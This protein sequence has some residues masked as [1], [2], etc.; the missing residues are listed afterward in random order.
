MET[1]KAIFVIAQNQFR[2]E[3]LF[4]TQK[5]LKDAGIKTQIAC[6]TTQEA[7]GKL[8]GKASPDMSVYDINPEEIDALIFVGGG[9]CMEYY[10]DVRVLGIAKQ[11]FYAGKIVAA[12]CAAPSILVNAGILQGRH[13]TSHESRMQHLKDMGTIFENKPVVEDGKIITASGPK[14]AKEFGEALVRHLGREANNSKE[15]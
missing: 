7:A 8:G 5:I 11:V 6:K 9:G 3:E 10:D 13:A 14:A 15:V 4:V 2:D 12:I 1:K